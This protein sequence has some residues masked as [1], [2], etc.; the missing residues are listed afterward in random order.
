MIGDEGGRLSEVECDRSQRRGVRVTLK[1][2]ES[3][4]RRGREPEGGKMVGGV[5]SDRRW[6]RGDGESVQSRERGSRERSGRC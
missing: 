4:Q 6:K 2:V 1:L 5:E 3:D